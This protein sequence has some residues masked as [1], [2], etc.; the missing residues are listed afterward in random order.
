MI[1]EVVIKKVVNN[2]IIETKDYI[3]E[4]KNIN[5]Y[6][7][8]KFVRKIT[9]SP[10]NLEEFGYGYSISEGLLKRVD[11]VK[12]SG[13]NIYIYGEEGKLN[14]KKNYNIDIKRAINYKVQPKYWKLTGAF[15]WAV[16]FIDNKIFMVE[17]IGRHNAIDKVVGFAV[18]NDLNLGNSI[19]RFSGRINSEIINKVI[20][21]NIPV[22]ISK[23]PP[24][25]NALL[26]AKEHNIK[27]IGFLRDNKYNI[28]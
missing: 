28:Y 25:Y 17:D 14:L 2:Q 4:E 22:I 24:T 7:N 11:D 26:L 9:L 16:L 15:H 20:N 3:A 19:L 5:I 27:I 18:K 12:I 21:S 1:R 23:A 13:D 8:D 10:N 6:I